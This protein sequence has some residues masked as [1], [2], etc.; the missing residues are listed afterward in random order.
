MPAQILS[1]AILPVEEYDTFIFDLY[2]TLVDIHTDEDFDAWGQLAMFYG[3]YGAHYTPWELRDSYRML[4]DEHESLL[5]HDLD[6]MKKDDTHESSPE[7]EITKIFSQL[8]ENKNVKADPALVL[9]ASQLF[10]IA[11]IEHLNLYPGTKKMLFTLRALGKKVYLLS[12]AQRVFT[13]YEMRYL[14]IEHFFDR[15]YISSDHETK[16]PDPRFFM[17]LLQECKIDTSR[18][19][20]VGNDGIADIKGSKMVGLQTF[21]VQSN[22]SPKEPIPE[23]T[24]YAVPNFTEW[25][26]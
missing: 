18:A 10:R 13:E 5:K 15:I 1:E 4:I 7:I 19:L 24:D 22:I 2:G 6:L 26:C 8:F 12:N 16:K 23:D 17:T 20:F 25:K 11:T 9:H 3:F 14:D 21:Y